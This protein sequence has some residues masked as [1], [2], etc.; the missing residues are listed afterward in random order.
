MRSSQVRCVQVKLG[1]VKIDAV[2]DLSIM[3]RLLARLSGPARLK[4]MEAAV[5][6]RCPGANLHFPREVCVTM[7]GHTLRG[8]VVANGK[9]FCLS[10][11]SLD[12][13]AAIY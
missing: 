12:I 8:V 3:P 7:R 1:K 6:R 4:R 2:V 5:G 13:F 9:L 10:A 11:A